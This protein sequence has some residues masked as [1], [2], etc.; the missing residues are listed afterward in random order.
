MKLESSS[1]KEAYYTHKNHQLVVVFQ[2]GGRY[3]YLQVPYP[4][5]LALVEAPSPGTYYNA[6]IKPHYICEGA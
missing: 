5:Y 3:T 1:I 2:K 4:V 6:E